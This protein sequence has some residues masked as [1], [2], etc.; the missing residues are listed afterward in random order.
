MTIS[1]AERL[2]RIHE[3]SLKHFRKAQSAVYEERKQCI[4]DRRFCSIAGGQW[5]GSL[6]DQFQNSP[7]FEFNLVQLACIR[8]ISEYRN[9]R[10]T[11]D[12]TSRDGS[13]DD[14]MADTCDGLYRADEQ[15]SGAQEAYD[16]AFEEAI[17]GGFGAYRL[18]SCYEDD[19]DDDNDH[20]RIRFESIP[21]ADS[22][23]F[24]D[25]DAKRQDK[26]DAKRAW[27]LHP[28]SYDAYEEEFGDDPATW[29]KDLD[30][31][32]FDWCTPDFV[33]VAEY[34][35]VEEVKE[36]VH[37]FE[38]LDKEAEEMRVPDSEYDEE[39]ASFLKAVGFKKVGE[40]KA[41]RKKVHKY[42]MSG[43]GVLE[44]CGYI[45]GNC[46]PIIPVYGKRWFVDGVER[47]MGHVRL[48]KD[49]Q[50]LMNMQAS[51]LAEIACLSP[52]EKPI[53]TRRQ[54]AGLEQYWADDP[55]KRYPFGLVNDM[56]DMNGQP[57]AAG[58]IGYTKSP[59]LPPA[60]AAILDF[61]G[62]AMKEILGNQQ[63]G[64]ELQPNMSGKAVELVQNRL[65]MQVFIYMSNFSSAVRRGGEVWLGMARDLYVEDGRKMKS[66]SYSGEANSV[67]IARPVYNEKTGKTERENDL[68]NAR[69]DA[70]ATVGPSSS[71]KRAATVRALSGLMLMQQDPQDLKILT[72][73]IMA[74]IEGEGLRDINDYYHKQMVRMGVAKPTDAEKEELM[75][76]MQNAQP[77]ANTQYLQ[78]AA[79]E[80]QAKAGKAQ[81][82]TVLT[83]AKAEQSRAETAKTLSDMQVSERESLL[84]TASQLQQAFQQNDQTQI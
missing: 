61:T 6:G 68:K 81:A 5:E 7:Q 77:D 23:V 60:M 50:R 3:R 17:T 14:Q 35:E 74:N 64:E 83:I 38:G 41:T 9:N 76:E 66:I 4:E 49:P 71:S 57:I 39:K 43:A 16:T 70:V 37:I 72:S 44:D 18:M 22:R 82:D 30:S 45:A 15:D 26:A 28:Y 56:E 20:Q 2:G 36:T 13:A 63:A 46:I 55:I 78:A 59:A 54:I 73:G 32:E 34:F 84:N 27:L 52:V 79:Q 42:L 21:D 75:Q 8:I 51:R 10:V 29:P 12:F 47:C 19:E 67:E 69:Y 33:Y 65:D 40:K 25:I 1:N 58:P 53:F 24:F 80:A 62:G 48:A 11:V 31:G